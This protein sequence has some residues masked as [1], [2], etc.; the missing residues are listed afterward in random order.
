M[1]ALAQLS[2]A[3]IRA[4]ESYRYARQ[5]VEQAQKFL[6]EDPGNVDLQCELAWALKTVGCEYEKLVVAT[7]ALSNRYIQQG[8][9]PISKLA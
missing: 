5:Q 3:R 9:P 8:K 6:S 2:Y 1:E 7:T 4:L